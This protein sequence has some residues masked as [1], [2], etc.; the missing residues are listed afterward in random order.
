MKHLTFCI[1]FGLLLPIFVIA[2][3]DIKTNGLSGVWEF[4]EVTL[5]D[6]PEIGLGPFPKSISIEMTGPNRGKLTLQLHSQ[7]KVKTYSFSKIEPIIRK[8]VQVY[9][10][11]DITFEFKPYTL[12][13]IATISY[14]EDALKV[15]LEWIKKNENDEIEWTVPGSY[16][17]TLNGNLLVF[18]RT[19]DKDIPEEDRVQT[20]FEAHY[21]KSQMTE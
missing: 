16:T 21:Q 15:D 10:K 17:F 14:S 7:S 12:E 18:H 9:D 11:P 13:E 5:H 2:H 19:N 4:M 8:T 20:A 1:Y 6:D 3:E